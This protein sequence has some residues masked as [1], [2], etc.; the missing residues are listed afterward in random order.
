MLKY[1]RNNPYYQWLEQLFGW[2]RKSYPQEQARGKTLTALTELNGIKRRWYEVPY[3]LDCLLRK[4]YLKYMR[5][6][7]CPQ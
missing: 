3:I 6:Y 4:R 7:G 1:D 5:G 2:V